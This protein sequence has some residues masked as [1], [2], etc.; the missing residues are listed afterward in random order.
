MIELKVALL[1]VLTG[2]L[3]LSLRLAPALPADN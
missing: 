1:A 3:L 2:T